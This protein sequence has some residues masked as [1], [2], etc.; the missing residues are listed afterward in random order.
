MRPRFC[1]FENVEGHITLGLST[2]ISDLA[3]MGYKTTWG[4]F[5]ASEVGAPHQRKRVFILAHDQKRENE[6]GDR[7]ELES[8]ERSGASSDTA[9]RACSSDELANNNNKGFQGL[10]QRGG[11][12]GRQEQQEQTGYFG[13]SCDV[14]PSRPGQ[15]QYEWEPSRVTRELAN[16]MR[17]VEEGRSAGCGEEES[18]RAYSEL[19]GSGLQAGEV[20]S[21]VGLHFNGAPNGVGMSAHPCLSDIEL[22]EIHEWMERSENRVDELRLLGNGV[23]P[24]TAARAWEV[25]YKRLM[26][27]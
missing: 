11:Q 27:N 16:A 9:F 2:V 10:W 1:F 8:A 25:L 7:R 4:I 23:V 18:R 17:P 19:G 22:A 6:F 5:S 21:D 12:E 15:E 24:A 20:E 3:E 26:E 13:G 14:W